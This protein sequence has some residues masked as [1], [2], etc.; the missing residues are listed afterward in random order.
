MSLDHS[1]YLAYGIEIPTT[2]DFDRLD[3]VLAEQ[4]RDRVEHLY[5][6]DYERLFLYTE[7]T[8]VKKNTAVVIG[9]NAYARYEITGWNKALHEIAARLGHEQHPLP[10]WLVL[11]DHS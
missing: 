8:E 7:S 3:Q 10:T 6:G 11:H 4:G 1:T 9:P 2:T 5:L